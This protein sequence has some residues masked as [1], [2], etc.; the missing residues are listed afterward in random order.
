MREAAGA[1]KARRHDGAAGRREWR[2]SA[3]DHRQSHQRAT[4]FAKRQRDSAVLPEDVEAEV[5]REML[6][7]MKSQGFKT[8]E[9]ME[10]AMRAAKLEPADIRQNFRSQFMRQAVM[11]RE[12]DAKIYYGLRQEE[13]K[14]YYEA[15]RTKFIKPESVELSEI[16]LS[17]TDK[18]EAD[19]R[20]RAAQIMAQARAGADFAALAVAHS[21]RQ[22]DGKPV[23][24]ETKGKVGRLMCRRYAPKLPPPSDVAKGG[25]TAPPASKTV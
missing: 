16:Y 8:L 14:K 22:Q 9:E 2:K 15:N 6:R 5:N 1:L 3:E 10:S 7:I 19:V 21:E 4:R 11:Q 20:A 24:P 23:A 12:V 25:V 13:L 17:F 18:A